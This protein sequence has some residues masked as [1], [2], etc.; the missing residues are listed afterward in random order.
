MKIT[1]GAGRKSSGPLRLG[2]LPVLENIFSNP[3]LYLMILP[4][5]AYY[6]IFHYIP[7]YG[8]A[9]AFKDFKVTRGIAGSAWIGLK[10]FKDLFGS[11]LFYGVLKNSLI[12]SL[13][14][15][16]WG[17]PAPII[18]AILLS[19][20]RNETFKRTAQTMIYLPHFISWV[21]ICG[22]VANFLTPSIEGPV[23]SLIRA[24][25]GKAINFLIQPRYFRP[26]IIFS[27]IWKDAGWGTII[28]LAS[29]SR[30]DP[31]LHEAAV[32]DGASRLQ[33]IWYITLPGIATTV[34]VILIL[35]MG[36]IL[37][38][39]FEQIY[40]LQNPL[41]YSVS[42]VFETFTYRVGL[43]DGRFGYSTAVGVFQSIVG[44]ILILITN[45]LSRRWS[46]SGLW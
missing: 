1:S 26:I 24:F 9:I 45:T 43:L 28:Y 21:V 19:E 20:L 23:N 22:I 44:M 40:M 5:F 32:V 39:G 8:I 3:L 12:L 30:I 27:E 7:I 38:N 2:K 46:G 6:I 29:I 16:I 14:R 13:Y 31:T 17:F 11:S 15:L 36:Y 37:S 4:G 42:D 34:L 25:G 33:R 41:T 10:N 18:F 35:R